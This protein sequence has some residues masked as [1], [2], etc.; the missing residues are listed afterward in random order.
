MDRAQTY[1]GGEVEVSVEPHEMR[2]SHWVYAP[3]FADIS[4]EQILFDLTGKLWDLISV[5]ESEDALDLQLRKYPGDRPQVT[6]QV[7]RKG[8]VILVA[9][10]PV[11]GAE[12]ERHL[13]T[14][15]IK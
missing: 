13:D 7:Q 6:L 4:G 9:G 12:L 3:K 1:W 11:D 14:A 15:L 10:K 5:S 8:R 2:M